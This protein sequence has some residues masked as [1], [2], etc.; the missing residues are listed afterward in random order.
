MELFE[1]RFRNIQSIQA[2]V[3]LHFVM[4]HRMVAVVIYLQGFER[5]LRC[6][7][8]MNGDAHAI[9]NILGSVKFG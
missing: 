4:Q 3:V 1:F 9:K 8:I 2:E 7:G 5:D 6:P